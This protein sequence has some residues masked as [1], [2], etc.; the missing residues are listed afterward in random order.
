M[1][2]LALVL[3]LALGS[4][5]CI[6]VH[7]LGSNTGKSFDGVFAQQAQPGRSG[8]WP[9]KPMEAELGTV[10]VGKMTAKSSAKRKTGFSLPL[11]GMGK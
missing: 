6:K 4:T 5:A 1:L 10:A 2:L 3:L 8:R 7:H 9:H 11:V